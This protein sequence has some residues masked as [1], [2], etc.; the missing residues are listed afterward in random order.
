MRRQVPTELGNKI[1]SARR[2]AGFKNPESF[3]AAL[4]VSPATVS[5]YE[6][7]RMVPSLA[8]LMKISAITGHSVGYFLEPAAA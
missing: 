7:G 1:Q 4:G 2:D 6:Q 8:R 5:R 3:A